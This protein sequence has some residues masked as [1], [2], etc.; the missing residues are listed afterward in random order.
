MKFLIDRC[1]GRRLAGWPRE[2]GHDVVESRERGVDPGDRALLAWADAEQR[3]LVTIDKD[4][5][6]ILFTQQADHSGLVRLPD[7]PALTRISLMRALLEGHGQDLES[8]A[9]ITIRSGRIRISLP[10]DR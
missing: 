5:G 2:Q 10:P 1:A 4:F 9:I 8:R 7:V 6:Q 3:I